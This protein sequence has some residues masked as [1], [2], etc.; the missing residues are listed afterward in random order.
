MKPWAIYMVFVVL[1]T[2]LLT[3]LVPDVQNAQVLQGLQF[4]ITTLG[5]LPV[6]PGCGIPR[7]TME[8]Y[9]QRLY[10]L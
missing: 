5:A 1:S 2:V 9:Y 3:Q 10:L 4:P 7:G 6:T 8:I